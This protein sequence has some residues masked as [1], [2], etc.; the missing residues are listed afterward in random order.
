MI[1]AMLLAWD[2]KTNWQALGIHFLFFHLRSSKC[3]GA[4]SSLAQPSCVRYSKLPISI[5]IRNVTLRYSASPRGAAIS[6]GTPPQALAFDASGF[7][8]VRLS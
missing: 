6:V 8:T 7:V 5:P 2:I 4:S 1:R 3:D